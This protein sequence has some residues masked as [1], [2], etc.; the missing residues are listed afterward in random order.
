MST[1]VLVSAGLDSAVLLASEARSGPVHPIYVSC[2]LAW[3][4][5]ELAALHRLLASAP[6]A[7][8]A[9]LAVLTFPVTDLYPA[10]HWA[11]RSEPPAYDTADED[12]YLAGR[13]VILL[14]KAAIYCVQH[15]IGRLAIGPL[16]GNPF[17]DATTSFFEAMATALSIGLAQR[18]VIAAPLLRMD[19]AA[20]IRCGAALGVP[21]ELT[22]SCMN[23]RAGRHCGR[24]S[25]CRE[26]REAFRNAG[27]ADATSYAAAP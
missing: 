8:A 10:S 4:A 13:N 18:I 23:P 11:L 5:E 14:S 17:P 3:E 20:V 25:K 2:G 1:A 15:E 24:C 7:D 22:L 27:M 19:K 6:Y 16:A 26:R 21:L 12:V 9:S